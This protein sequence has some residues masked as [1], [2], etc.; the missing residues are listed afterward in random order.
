MSW[1][2]PVAVYPELVSLA[3]TTARYFD[4]K[5]QL[6]LTHPLVRT[7][8]RRLRERTGTTISYISRFVKQKR[9]K[10]AEIVA[11]TGFT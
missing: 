4:M 8:F 1:Q 5:H 10:Y 2:S 6:P 7:S 3:L 9:P 11:V